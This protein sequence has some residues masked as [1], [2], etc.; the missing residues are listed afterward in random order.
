MDPKGTGTTSA[1]IP[2]STS[3]TLLNGVPNLCD[4]NMVRLTR[5]AVLVRTQVTQRKRGT[6]RCPPRQSPSIAYTAMTRLGV[7]LLVGPYCRVQ[8]ISE[9]W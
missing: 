9:S 4:T 7:L 3:C 6:K 5:L 1:R 8:N 2:C